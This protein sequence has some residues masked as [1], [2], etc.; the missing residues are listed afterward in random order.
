VAK[1]RK[2]ISVSKQVRQRFDVQRLDLKKLDD[3]ELRKS[4]R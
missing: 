4:T 2:R 3:K 1:L